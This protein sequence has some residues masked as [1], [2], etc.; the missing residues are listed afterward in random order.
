MTNVYDILEFNVIID[1]LKNYCFTEQAK[2]NFSKLTPY[3]SETE[4]RAALRETTEA[5]IILDNIGNPPLVSMK[6]V[7]KH[8]ITA[9]QG[10]M[11]IPEQLDYLG[12]V[13]TAIRRMKDFL[14]RSKILE[15]SLPYYDENLNSLDELRDEIQRSIRNNQ[16]DDYATNELRDLRRSISNLEEKIKNKAEGMLKTNTECYSD[17]FISNRNGHICL[18]VKK[19]YRHKIPGSV[20]DKSSTGAT[21]FIEPEAISIMSSELVMLRLDEENEVRKILYTLTGLIADNS[22][23]FSENM[24]V[25]A[26]LDFIFAKGKLSVDFDAIAPAINTSRY[27][28][29]VNGRHPLMDK[30]ICVPLNIS[31]GVDSDIR[32]I[33]ITG[34]NTGGKTVAIKTV[35]LLSIMAQSGLHIPCEDADICMN[36]QVLCDIGDGQNITENLSTFSAHITNILDILKRVN[37]ESLV[38]LDELGSGT[39]PTEGMGIAIAILDELTNNG[40]LFLATTHYPEVKQYAEEK[41]GIINARMAFDRETLKPLYRLEL[42]KAGE[43]C[44][45]YIAKRL[46]MPYGIIERA[47]KE[48]YGENAMSELG[49]IYSGEVIAERN[50]YRKEYFGP[51]IKTAITNTSS[52]VSKRAKSFNVGDSVLVYPEKKVGIVCRTSNDNG[53]IMVQMKKMKMLINHKRLKLLVPASELYPENYDFSIV[54]DTVANRKARHKMEKGHQ[55]DLEIKIDDF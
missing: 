14:N 37:R 12:T 45:L 25:I 11:L 43:S 33:V 32:G 10:G 21:L 34:P 46:G 35:G 48:A 31:M 5:R 42:G 30:N 22:E 55:P 2:E 4:V 36:S 3:L 16:V 49:L 26:K 29:I 38:I 13:L 8:L 53:E 54:F 44:A 51:R 47:C 27:L 24:R 40:C 9:K 23:I 7:D 15:I 6:D 17:S 20:I 50:S 19:E 52:K 1:Q 18:P 28:K 39:D 41:S